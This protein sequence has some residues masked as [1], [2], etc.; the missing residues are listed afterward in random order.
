MQ[1]RTVLIQASSR[2]KGDTGT[3]VEYLTKKSNIDVI[4]LKTK[5]IG[6]FDYNFAN[7]DDDFIPLL[8]EIIANY[9]TIVFATPVYWYTMSGLLKVFFD[10]LSDLL[11]YRKE[12]GRKLR[13]KKM[14]MVSISNTDDLKSGYNM[15]F[16]ESANYLGMQY[17]GD[18]HAWVKDGTIPENVTTNL[19][20][21]IKKLN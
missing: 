21:F 10:R 6:H 4:D 16:K 2:S 1:N 11:H 12:L 18:V 19:D 9:D 17:L 14:A 3:I 8:E 20:L 5:T 7:A 13:G 15:P